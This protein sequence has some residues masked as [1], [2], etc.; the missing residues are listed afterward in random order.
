MLRTYAAYSTYYCGMFSYVDVHYRLVY[1]E[2][3][4]TKM[5]LPTS[6]HVLLLLLLAS[7]LYIAYFLDLVLTDLPH[8]TAALNL[9]RN[10]SGIR[11][12]NEPPCWYRNIIATSRL[13]WILVLVGRTTTI[14]IATTTTNDNQSQ[15]MHFVGTE[16]SM[17]QEEGTVGSSRNT[18]SQ[19]FVQGCRPQ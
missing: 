13:G 6:N 15:T 12:P 11:I 17:L 18:T 16:H 10:S 19:L 1:R 3:L 14:P 4:C 2:C 7:I 5:K 8:D 9:K